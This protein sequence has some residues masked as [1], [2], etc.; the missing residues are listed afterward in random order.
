[1][2]GDVYVHASLLPAG[3]VCGAS[4]LL[5]PFDAE[6]NI[7][8]TRLGTLNCAEVLFSWDEAMDLPSL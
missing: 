4:S 3:I 8:R 6:K 1:M 5:A 7:S 2:L